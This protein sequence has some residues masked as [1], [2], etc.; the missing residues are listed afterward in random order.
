M[1]HPAS[2]WI[3]STASPVVIQIAKHSLSRASLFSTLSIVI[4][5]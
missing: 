2:L 4:M 1:R 3:I 5:F